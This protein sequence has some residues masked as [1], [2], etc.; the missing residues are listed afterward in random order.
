MYGYVLS[1]PINYVDPYGLLRTIVLSSENDFSFN[2]GG[3]T[4]FRQVRV[5]FYNTLL[6]PGA[7]VNLASGPV[8]REQIRYRDAVRYTSSGLYNLSPS[9]YDV[10]AI[11]LDKGV[12]NAANLC[13]TRV[14]IELY[15][16]TDPIQLD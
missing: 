15:E 9:T 6:I 4:K 7:G 13:G 14:K 3:S 1:D 2:L 8:R 5:K 16:F 12:L 11:F 10:D